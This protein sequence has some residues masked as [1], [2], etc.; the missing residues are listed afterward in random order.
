MMRPVW[1]AI[2]ILSV[3]LGAVG[4]FL[5]FL[6]TVPFMIA[7]AFCFGKSS[8]RL[9]RWL[10]SN[11]R[12]GPPIQNWRDRGAIP[13]RAKYLTTL[14]IL[15]APLMTLLMGF[16]VWVMLAQ[17]VALVAVAAFVWTRPD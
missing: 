9:E 6:P 14:S 11:P 13:R 7:A 4:V 5:P 10:L 15:A 1:A 2:G 16:G 12:F 17:C 8:A 3:T